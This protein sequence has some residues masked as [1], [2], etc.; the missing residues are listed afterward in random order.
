M[1][2]GP[3]CVGVRL[4]PLQNKWCLL[5]MISR[6]E[7]KLLDGEVAVPDSSTLGVEVK[8]ALKDVQMRYRFRDEYPN[9]RLGN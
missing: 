6:V 5:C 2:F 8:P 1:A 9:L 3:G 7:M 4:A